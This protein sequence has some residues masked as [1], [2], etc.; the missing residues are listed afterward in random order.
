MGVPQNFRKRKEKDDY[1]SACPD[2]VGIGFCYVIHA[3]ALSEHYDGAYFRLSRWRPPG[4]HS[5]G[6]LAA[7]ATL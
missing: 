5:F 7:R 6:M 4:E 3:M 2:V 1:S